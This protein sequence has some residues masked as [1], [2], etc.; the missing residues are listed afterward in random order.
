M[1][2]NWELNVPETLLVYL[3]FLNL[4]ISVSLKHCE[5]SKYLIKGLSL[6]SSDLLKHFSQFIPT[7]LFN[8]LRSLDLLLKITLDTCL[9]LNLLFNVPTIPS[10]T[11]YGLSDYP[12]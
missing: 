5:N 3:L 2:Y 6:F 12:P 11:G 1:K 7:S 9:V 8:E 4:N 10:I